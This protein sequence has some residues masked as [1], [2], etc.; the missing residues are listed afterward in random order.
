M[1]REIGEG[2]MGCVDSCMRGTFTSW[3]PAESA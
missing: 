2:G 3:K 1:E